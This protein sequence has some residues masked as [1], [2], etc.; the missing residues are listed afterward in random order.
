[1]QLESHSEYGIVGA[2]NFFNNDHSQVD[3][4]INQ[5]SKKV[6]NPVR[7]P[8]KNKLSVGKSLLQPI[9]VKSQRPQS[10]MEDSN[11]AGWKH[12]SHGDS[13]SQNQKPTKQRRSSERRIK[14]SA[15][16]GG[17]KRAI[18]KAG[19]DAISQEQLRLASH[20][21]EIKEFGELRSEGPSNES[22]LIPSLRT[23]KLQKK[24]SQTGAS[25]YPE[26]QEMS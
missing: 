26:Y 16:Y 18:G 21:V 14:E 11:S 1:M 6:K 24:T 4:Q 7:V 17:R 20:I 12:D 5:Y 13:L 19:Y 25:G 2:S 23:L 22:E 9:P 3:Q 15:E 8:L 10:A